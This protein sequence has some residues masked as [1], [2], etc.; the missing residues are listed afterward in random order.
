MIERIS[1]MAF[2]IYVGNLS[3]QT[4]S[5]DLRELFAQVGTVERAQVAEDRDTGRSRGFGFVEMATK[6]EGETAIQRFNGQDL[7]G[8]NLTV[9]EAKPRENRGYAGAG[10]RS[11]W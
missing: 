9:N 3:F 10:G 11:G 4:T 6:E 1:L 8:R 2:N 5:A 7:A